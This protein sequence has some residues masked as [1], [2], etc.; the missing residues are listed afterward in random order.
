[1]LLLTYSLYQLKVF[2]VRHS[3]DRPFACQVCGHRS[4]S[5]SDLLR[6]DTSVH[7][8]AGSHVHCPHNDCSYRAQTPRAVQLHVLKHHQL[9]VSTKA[10]QK[11]YFLPLPPQVKQYCCHLCQNRYQR[12]EYLTEHLKKAHQI[13]W[14]SGHSRFRYRRDDD[15]MFRLQTVRFEV[16]EEATAT[17]TSAATV[18]M[19]GAEEE[20][21]GCE[22]EEAS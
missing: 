19:E 11:Q 2:W 12:G 20:Q 18:I 1:M 7:K 4:K 17:A 3:V 22:V 21:D 5:L 8:N 6:H 9:E 16:A 10:V 15:G 13:K 14:P